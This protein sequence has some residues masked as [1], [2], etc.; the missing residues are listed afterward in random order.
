MKLSIV[1][2][3]VAL[4]LGA[5]SFQAAAAND[6]VIT[7][8]GNI[9]D[10]TCLVEGQ[11]PGQNLANKTVTLDN[12]PASVLAAAGDVATA[13]GFTITV[14]GAG[15][16][17]CTDGQTAFVRF[18]PTSAAIDPT[19]GR[20]N[21]DTGTGAASNVQVQVLN[22]NGSVIDLRTQNSAG[23]VIA[24]NTAVIPLAAQYYATGAATAGAANSRVG[25]Q[26]VYN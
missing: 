19:S 3:A 16:T 13:K 23:V 10:T 12:V 18:D 7:F 21:I 15:D 8:N 25:Y 9:T 20:L 11:Q 1:S 4:A 24:N 2:A 6:G 5:V 14:G 26:I 22:Q 17:G